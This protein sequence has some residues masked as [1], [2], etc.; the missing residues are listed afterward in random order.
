MLLASTSD[1]RG[2]CHHDGFAGVVATLGAAA[3]VAGFASP[4]SRCPVTVTI[5]SLTISVAT[6]V[7]AAAWLA[8]TALVS[9][10]CDT[11]TRT[12]ATMSVNSAV[13]RT[14]SVMIHSVELRVG[15]RELWACWPE[16]SLASYETISIVAERP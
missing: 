6:S 1:R 2:E 4:A 7:L 3:T 15:R 12:P 8:R 11:M 9:M 16:R 13:L 10:L 14:L 5:G